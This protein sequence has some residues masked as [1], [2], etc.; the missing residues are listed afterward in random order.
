MESDTQTQE[1]PEQRAERIAALKAELAEAEGVSS[2]PVPIKSIVDQL[3]ELP[4]EGSP[5][6]FVSNLRTIAE[7]LKADGKL[8]EADFLTPAEQSGVTAVLVKLVGELAAKI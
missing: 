8:V 5:H 7:E 6:A 2:E 4:D 3:K 1:T